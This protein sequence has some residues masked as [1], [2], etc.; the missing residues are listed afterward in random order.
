ME[1][2]L[3]VNI[4]HWNSTPRHISVESVLT[5]KSIIR[6]LHWSIVWWKVSSLQIYH[7]N[8]TLRHNIIWVESVLTA[9]A[10]LELYTEAYCGGTC[11]H[12]KNTLG[13]P[14][15]EY[16]LSK[17]VRCCIK[18]HYLFTTEVKW[19][20]LEVAAFSF[21]LC[22]LDFMEFHTLVPHIVLYKQELLPVSLKFKTTL[23]YLK[24]CN[25]TLL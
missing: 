15:E 23:P 17:K 8:S 4:H 16:E 13:T 2:V 1:S 24:Y 3:T 12:S 20:H 7:W 11:P 18:Q 10:S 5:A 21:L 9:K 25:P 6:T 19:N 22:L 14:I